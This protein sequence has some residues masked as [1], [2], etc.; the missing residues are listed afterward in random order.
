ML[1]M[2]ISILSDYTPIILILGGI[3]SAAWLLAMLL[4][5]APIVGNP[6][7]KLLK[8]ISIFG[9]LVGILLLLTGA[10]IWPSEIWDT[11][12]KYLLIITGLS[13]FLKPLRQIPWAAL[14]GLIIGSVCFFIVY[15]YFP[16]P[17]MIFNISSTWFYLAIFFIPALATYLFFKFLEDLMKLIGLILSSKPVATILGVICI[18]HGILLLLNQ[19]LFS[20]LGL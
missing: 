8:V 13:L 4:K 16:L 14:V 11:A 9:F 3:S 7:S 19:N 17:Q 18:S 10:A 6:M 15:L 1:E 20:I 2:S 5:S 12:T